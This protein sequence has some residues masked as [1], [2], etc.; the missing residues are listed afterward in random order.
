[1]PF[2]LKL[3]RSKQY[4][5]ASKNIFV[6]SVKPLDNNDSVECT[7]SSQSL[8]LECL[9]NVCQKLQIQQEHYFGLQFLSKQGVMRWL[10]LERPVKKQLDK[11]AQDMTLY[12]R[13]LYFVTDVNL[14]YDEVTR[15]QYFLQL[16]SDVIEGKLP[17]SQEQAILLASYSLQAEFSDH[18]PERHT[19]EY[20]SNFAL[21][22]KHM[23]PD[24][25]IQGALMEPVI[26]AHRSLQGL[27]PS[28]AEI[29]YILEAQ[30]LE[31]YGQDSYITKDHNREDV[32]IA[33]S[34]FGIFVKRYNMQPAEC[35]RWNEITNL[36]LNKKVFIIE[37]HVKERTFSLQLEDVDSAKYVWKMCAQQHQFHFPA[38]NNN[39][40]DGQKLQ[41]GNQ[42]PCV[43]NSVF[44]N[45]RQEGNSEAVLDN[46]QASQESLDELGIYHT[47]GSYIEHRPFSSS[48]EFNKEERNINNRS[49]QGQQQQ[50][51]QHHLSENALSTTF[52]SSSSLHSA[53]ETCVRPHTVTAY[54]DFHAS[55]DMPSTADLQKQSEQQNYI[56][57]ELSLEKRR[58]LLP[59][60]R[61]A[62]DY[63]TAIH[64][65]YGIQST[66][67]TDTSIHSGVRQS[68]TN[69]TI[70]DSQ[71]DISHSYHQAAPL[72]SY[73]QYKNYTD[74][75]HLKINGSA[76]VVSDVGLGLSRSNDLSIPPSHTYS[77]PELTSQGLPT[78]LTAEQLLVN[79]HLSYQY[80]PPPPY[81]YSQRS[82]SSTPD[83]TKGHQVTS[84]SPDLV[85]RRN[86]NNYPY[87][88]ASGENHQHNALGVKLGSEPSIYTDDPA[89]TKQFV[90]S[91]H[92]AQSM[93]IVPQKAAI[94]MDV[95]PRCVPDTT[96]GEPQASLPSL[97][98]LSAVGHPALSGVSQNIQ[99][100]IENKLFENPSP[101]ES[102]TPVTFLQENHIKTRTDNDAVPIQSSQMGSVSAPQQGGTPTYAH[103]MGPMMVAAMNGLTL[104][105]PDMLQS[106]QDGVNSPRDTKIQMLESKLGEGE[107][108]LEFEQIIKKKPTT[109][110]LTAL[111]P[112]NISRNRFKDV[113]PYEENRV[114]LTPNKEN[115]SG[116]I[117]ASHIT[118]SIGGVQ[119]FY[120]AAQAPLSNTVH[121]FWQMIWEHRVSVVVMVTGIQEQGREK[122]FAYWPQNDKENNQLK[123]GEF[124]IIR[125]YS[126]SSATYITCS[127]VIKHAPSR[128]QRPVWHIQ[129]TDWPDHGC[130]LNLQGFINFMEQ[131]DSVRRLALNEQPPE[132]S[133][134][135]PTLIHCSAGVGRTG[136]VMLCDI[137]FYSLDHNEGRRPRD[138]LVCEYALYCSSTVVNN[139]EKTAHQTNLFISHLDCFPQEREVCGLFCS[140]HLHVLRLLVILLLLNFPTNINGLIDFH[141]LIHSHPSGNVPQLINCERL[142]GLQEC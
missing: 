34:K 100:Q 128:T 42:G 50:A 12:L 121:S 124:H 95:I 135:S 25:N 44:S 111:L 106:R 86:L 8:G 133:R 132:R 68:R 92:P 94:N 140:F 13:V 122:S 77:T 108:F 88:I 117:N 134:N 81:P 33:V 31:G 82:S 118:V 11:H 30:Q 5:V 78:D 130:P 66:S 19:P 62:P 107:V 91:P 55:E 104:S 39:E 142:I 98:S 125:N 61:Q 110:I 4:N 97:P 43:Q 23:I 65:K 141:P 119:R 57:S 84:T 85:S 47:E 36:S 22:P 51:L 21:L 87:V 80:K 109:Q 123:V 29:Y 67:L 15:N 131:I 54:Y 24:R 56:H 89:V 41:T 115:K 37:C 64:Q 73:T 69:S 116:Y 76:G 138:K 48:Q 129:Y 60:Y 120:I 136:V 49:F 7:L 6:I 101:L 63:E 26:Q 17:C 126:V 114:R 93:E 40:V 83:L 16:K 105:P 53:H 45:T 127:L 74:L 139:E 59:C 9:S 3:K 2:K 46:F 137:L 20:L 99:H 112:E 58:A 28:L 32:Y 113:L 75:S 103:A 71:V 35:F 70:T 27:L 52:T 18:S 79:L 102:N 38:K 1:M 72:Q 90:S 14:L 10:D 96:F